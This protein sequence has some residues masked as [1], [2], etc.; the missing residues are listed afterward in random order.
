LTNAPPWTFASIRL[1]IALGVLVPIVQARR[2]FAGLQRRDV[3]TVMTA[4]LLL[5][6]GVILGPLRSQPSRPDAS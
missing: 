6:A 2:R 5:L 1:L 3:A 4:G